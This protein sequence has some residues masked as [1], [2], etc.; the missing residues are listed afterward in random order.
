MASWQEVVTEAPELADR[1]RAVF[2]LRKHKALATLRRDGSPRISG[3][4]VEFDA[5]EVWLGMMP[6]SLK[7]CDVRRDPRIALQAMSDDPPEHDPGEW[8]GDAKIA[9]VA[10][11]VAGENPQGGHRFKVDVTE[12]VLTRVGTPPDHL[13]IESWHEGRGFSEHKRH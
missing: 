3:I 11:E 2:D 10:V 8:L 4:E 1:A 5:D 12:V 9:G 6:G 13:L 7:A